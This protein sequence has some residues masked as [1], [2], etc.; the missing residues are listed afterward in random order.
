MKGPSSVH[1]DRGFAS[2]LWAEFCSKISNLNNS[3]RDRGTRRSKYSTRT[4]VDEATLEQR[5]AD[6]TGTD[7][8]DITVAGIERATDLSL[9][10]G[11]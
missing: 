5:L 10:V 4:H 11:T 2:A 6:P 7:V 1:W 8:S 9:H 3:W